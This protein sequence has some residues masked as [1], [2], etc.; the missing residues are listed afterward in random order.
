MRIFRRVVAAVL[1]VALGYWLWMYFFPN[2]Q[3]IIQRQIAELARAATFTGDESPIAKLS[4]LSK[5]ANFFTTDVEITFDA[6]REG[7]VTVQGR[8]EIMGFGGAVLNRPGG[9]TVDFLDV[10]VRVAENRETATVLL[11]AR[12]QVPGQREFSVQEMKF[13]LKKIKRDWFISRVETVKTLSRAMPEELLAT[14]P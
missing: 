6:P 7:K 3:K 14:M 11:T 2:D 12:A 9:M 1:V 5:F 10:T 4:S 13:T 8:D